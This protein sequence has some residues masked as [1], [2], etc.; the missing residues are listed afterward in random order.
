M[1]L[2]SGYRRKFGSL[3]SVKRKPPP[4]SYNNPIPNPNQNH[5]RTRNPIQTPE[6]D[7]HRAAAVCLNQQSFS[8]DVPMFR[9]PMKSQPL[10]VRISKNCDQ[11]NPIKL[12]LKTTKNQNKPNQTL[13]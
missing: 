5:F 11:S 9:I 10:W 7:L 2:C 8:K 13:Q 1:I 4:Q 6:Q 12:N 3:W